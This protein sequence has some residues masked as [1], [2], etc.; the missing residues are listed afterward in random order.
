MKALPRGEHKVSI[1]VKD[2]QGSGDVQTVTVKLCQCSSDGTCEATDKSVSFGPLGVLAMLLPLALLLLLCEFL[3]LL[4]KE[5]L[6]TLECV[7][8]KREKKRNKSQDFNIF[9][10]LL[11]VYSLHSSA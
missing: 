10:L 11:Q 5:I 9:G 3:L 2:V 6:K 4:K 7:Y 1:I 8:L